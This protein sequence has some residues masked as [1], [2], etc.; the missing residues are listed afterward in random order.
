MGSVCFLGTIK[1]LK[2]SNPVG[3]HYLFH[4]DFELLFTIATTKNPASKMI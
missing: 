1:L 4:T 2:L 3:R